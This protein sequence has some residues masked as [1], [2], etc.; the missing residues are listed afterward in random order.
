MNLLADALPEAVEIDGRAVPIRTDFRTCLR[1]ILAFE[2]RD[3][4][5][6]EKHAIL[7][8]NLYPEPPANL[9]AAIRQGIKFLDGGRGAVDGEE[10]ET[11][12]RLYSFTK[13][14]NLI[15]AAFR[16][17]H[18]I[19]L[20]TEQ[21]H[22]WQFLALFSDLGA[23]TAFCQLVSLRRR[24]KTGRA[25]KEELRIARE[26]GDAFEVDDPE[27]TLAPEEQERL[28]EFERLVE[29]GRKRREAQKAADHS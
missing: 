28:D 19:D 1:V 12:P 14:S 9:E 25:S 22:W 10:G 18:G 7:L 17:T 3:L 11:G 8:A 27:E 24:V 26:M 16:Q 4:T 29:E 2:D 15:Y 13:D 23:D 5:A 21:L 20:A 6:S